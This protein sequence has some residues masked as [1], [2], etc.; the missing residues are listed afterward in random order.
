M[1][2]MQRIQGWT[3][4]ALGWLSP[5]M[6]CRLSGE[7]PV[8]IDGQVLDPQLQLIRAI[9]RRQSPYGYCEPDVARARK[10]L[11]QEAIAFRGPVT[12]VGPVRDFTIPGEGAPLRVRHYAPQGA[13]NGAPRPLLVYLHGGGFVVCDLETHDEACRILCKYADTHVLSVEYRLAPEHPFPAGLHD[14]EAALRWAQANAASLGADPAQIGIGGDSAGGNFAAVASRLAA[15]AGTPPA[16]QLLIYPA[17]DATKHRPSH[18]LFGDTFFLHLRDLE[19]FSRYYTG[20]TGVPPNDPRV[21]PLHA[22]DLH[23]LPPALVITAGFDVLRDE[24]KAYADALAAAGN[25]VEVQHH[26]SLGHAF[27]NMTGVVPAARRAMIATAE[28]WQSLLTRAKHAK[29]E[30]V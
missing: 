29:K 30:T 1:S 2:L 9:R 18:K 12:Q 22:P 4:P 23:D 21:S 8:T 7:P 10:R 14:A 13:S 28:A 6:Q 24:G 11:L 19:H 27:I 17:T 20:G 3:A 15:R 16:A 26:P 25:V 5:S